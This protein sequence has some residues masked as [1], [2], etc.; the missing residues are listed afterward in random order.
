M[1]RIVKSIA[2]LFLVSSCIGTDYVDDPIVGEQIE[3][4]VT[5]QALLVGESFV[6]IATYF[7]QY[8]IEKPAEFSWT[9]SN[10]QVAT[11]DSNGIVKA[12]GAGQTMVVAAVGGTVSSSLTIIVVDNT[13]QVA[14]IDISSPSNKISLA[15][16]ESHMLEVS[17]KNINGEL[18][19]DRTVE[20][21]SENSA[22]ATVQDGIV[23]GVSNGLVDIHAKVE[24][25]KSNLLSFSIG[26][27]LSGTF[28]SAGGYKAIGMASLKELNGDVVLEFSN[29]FETSF[30]LGTFVYMANV[31]NGTQVKANGLEVAQITSNGA[32]TFNLSALQSDIKL[33]DYKYVIILCKPASVTF[34]FAELK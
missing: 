15:I 18:L 20:W 32:K 28:V 1:I 23:R 10:I 12:I 5:R 3:L 24:G 19:T 29:N 17:V 6:V 16:G 27:G 30:A 9:S 25:V 7:D 21:F 31:T 14:S 26:S 22:I 33:T 11:I 2:I 34:G 4:N 8:G 13:I